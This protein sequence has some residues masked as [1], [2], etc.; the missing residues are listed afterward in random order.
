MILKEYS[1]GMNSIWILDI[2]SL[3]FTLNFSDTFEKWCAD[4]TL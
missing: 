2:N 4:N 3:G 1:S